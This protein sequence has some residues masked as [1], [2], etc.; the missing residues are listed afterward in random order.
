MW[1][2]GCRS[3]IEHLT[4]ILK[5]LGL[6]TSLKI[7]HCMK[8]EIRFLFFFLYVKNFGYSFGTGYLHFFIVFI[9]LI[10]YLGIHM[11]IL[12]FKQKMLYK[13]LVRW[14]SSAW[15]SCRG[16]G[17]VPSTRFS[18]QHPCQMAH[19]CLYLQLRRCDALG[20]YRYMSI[21]GTNKLTQ[22]YIYINKT[23][24]KNPRFFY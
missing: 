11:L 23:K 22:L 18:S 21:Y 1:G 24:T 20:F 5:A 6:T 15:W 17:L 2:W 14:L 9:S 3:V 19:N 16:P 7:K 12:S 10:C 13:G 4:H 8:S